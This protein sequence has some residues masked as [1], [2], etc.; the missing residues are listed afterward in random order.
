[1]VWL[2]YVSLRDYTYSIKC[3]ARIVNASCFKLIKP[4]FFYS[5]FQWNFKAIYYKIK[6]SN[7]VIFQYLER[8]LLFDKLMTH[9]FWIKC[10]IYKDKFWGEKN[11]KMIFVSC[12]SAVRLSVD[13]KWKYLP[14]KKI[15]NDLMECYNLRLS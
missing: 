9:V 2:K 10:L 11:S 7:T 12:H 13:A 5:I 1:M 4:W 8:K 6:C 14:R 3:D 15:D